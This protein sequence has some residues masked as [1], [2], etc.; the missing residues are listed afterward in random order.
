MFHLVSP[1][2]GEA[3]LKLCTLDRK[4][5][6]SSELH[7]WYVCLCVPYDSVR[8]VRIRT[9]CMRKNFVLEIA[10]SSRWWVLSGET[11]VVLLYEYLRQWELT[12]EVTVLKWSPDVMIPGPAC[13]CRRN[14]QL[15]QKN[16]TLLFDLYFK[17]RHLFA[18]STATVWQCNYWKMKHKLATSLVNVVFSSF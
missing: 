9:W 15:E 18:K 14:L 10:G 17:F 12:S 7:M 1:L 16:A 6:A 8:Q 5:F 3:C 2:A 4:Y 11:L 13:V